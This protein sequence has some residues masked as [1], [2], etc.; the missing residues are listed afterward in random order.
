MSTALANSRPTAAKVRR[1]TLGIVEHLTRNRSKKAPEAQ[2][3]ALSVLS[4]SSIPTMAKV[5]A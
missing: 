4:R 5:L 2:G 3:L 1:I